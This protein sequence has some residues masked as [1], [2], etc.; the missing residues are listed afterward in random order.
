MESFGK[1]RIRWC[2][3]CTQ[4]W[5]EIVKAIDTNELYVCCLECE[6]EWESP[7]DALDLKVGTHD[8]YGMVTVPTFEE[9]CSKGWEKYISY[10]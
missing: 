6:T 9:V 4:G 2:P 5:I 3:I 10:K 8:L 7:K 1:Y